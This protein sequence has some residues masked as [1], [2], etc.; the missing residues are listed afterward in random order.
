M[1]LIFS[2]SNDEFSSIVWTK[3]TLTTRLIKILFLVLIITSAA[4]RFKSEAIR[5]GTSIN[6]AGHRT[7]RVIKK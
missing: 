2:H 6:P 4:V 7:S 5:E 3:M 1:L